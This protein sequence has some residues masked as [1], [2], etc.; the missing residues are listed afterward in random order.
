MGG[1]SG[2]GDE[3]V[4]GEVLD[5]DACGKV[6]SRARDTDLARSLTEGVWISSAQV[7]LGRDVGHVLVGARRIENPRHRSVIAVW[8][9]PCDRRDA[10]PVITALSRDGVVLSRLGPHEALDTHTWARLRDER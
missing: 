7:R 6:L 4:D 2:P 1:G 10:R 3:P 9:S 8:V 5:V